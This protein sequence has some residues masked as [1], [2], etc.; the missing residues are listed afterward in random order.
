METTGA[1][2]KF[3]AI[4]V[5]RD[6]WVPRHLDT[7]MPRPAGRQSHVPSPKASASFWVFFFCLCVLL[8]SPQ[9]IVSSVSGAL[10]LASLQVSSSLFSSSSFPPAS[11]LLLLLSLF[12]LT[13][14]NDLAGRI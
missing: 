3:G 10:A 4:L 1:K 2:E 11:S 12:S 5:R 13:A 6:A 8:V 7:W 14:R 9:A